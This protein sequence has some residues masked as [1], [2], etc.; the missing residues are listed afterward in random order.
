MRRIIL[1]KNDNV[2]AW[3][4]TCINFDPGKY[5]YSQN[6]GWNYLSIPKLKV[7]IAEV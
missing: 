1:E 5:K 4:W 3:K 2:F 6:V 7:F